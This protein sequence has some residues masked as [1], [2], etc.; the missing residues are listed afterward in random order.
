LLFNYH[1]EIPEAEG[2]VEMIRGLLRRWDEAAELARRMVDI[3]DDG[4]HR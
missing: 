1:A 3:V 4:E 2:A